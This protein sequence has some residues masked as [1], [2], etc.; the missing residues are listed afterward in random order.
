MRQSITYKDCPFHVW[1]PSS[2]IEHFPS[3]RKLHKRHTCSNKPR[4]SKREVE[5]TLLK[6]QEPLLLSTCTRLP[7]LKKRTL[8]VWIWRGYVASSRANVILSVLKLLRKCCIH[9][10]NKCIKQ[11]SYCRAVAKL[12]PGGSLIPE[13]VI[14]C[15]YWTLQNKIIV[16]LPFYILPPTESTQGTRP[17]ATNFISL[18]S[19]STPKSSFL[20]QYKCSPRLQR[21]KHQNWSVQQICE[22]R[23]QK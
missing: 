8:K 1:L 15:K 11:V 10:S 22:A 3:S 23:R 18:S 13:T 21:F 14:H 9:M 12:L 6:R 2:Q 16:Q 4:V 7:R 19:H 17:R 20:Y 5:R